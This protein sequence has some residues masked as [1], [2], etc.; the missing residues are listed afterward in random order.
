MKLRARRSTEWVETLPGYSPPPVDFE[1]E[2]WTIGKRR[3]SHW[4]AHS[5]HEGKTFHLKWFLHGRCVTPGRTEWRNARRL[6]EAKIPNVVAVGW[7]RHPR[8]SFCV[9]EESPGFPADEWRQHGL[10]VRDLRSLS[11]SLAVYV[12]RLHDARLCH[13]D[14]NVYHVLVHQGTVRIIDVGRVCRFVRRRWII[15]D[16]ASLL[17][18]ARREGMP[19][20]VARVFLA[21]YLKETRHVW[22]RRALVGAVER[23]ARRYRRHNEKYG[24]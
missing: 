11:E 6:R 9:L 22:A 13:R 21:R 1:L 17:D 5:R 23:K 20:E 24:R 10:S 7:G 2:N 19:R 12:A 3:A 4:N 16:L 18:T 8:G 15:K 14:L